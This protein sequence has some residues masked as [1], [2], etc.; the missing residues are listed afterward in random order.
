VGE[1][2]PREEVGDGVLRASGRGLEAATC[3]NLHLSPRLQKP[4]RKNL[5]YPSGRPF[6]IPSQWSGEL[7]SNSGDDD[8]CD[9]C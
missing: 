8:K 5:Q 7:D 2:G 9:P 6:S 3:G 1:W 4:W